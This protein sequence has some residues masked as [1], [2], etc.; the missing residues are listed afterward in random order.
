M[1][2]IAQRLLENNT[3]LFLGSGFSLEAKNATGTTVPSVSTL[4]VELLDA[5]GTPREEAES[6]REPLTDIA[7]Y[8]LATEAGAAAVASRLRQ[9]FNVVDLAPWQRELVTAFPWKRI[10]TTNYDNAVEVACAAKRKTV[11]VLSALAPFER[12]QGAGRTV[13]HINGCAASVTPKSIDTEV[14]LSGKSYAG[15]SSFRVERNIT[16]SWS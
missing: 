1:D 11:T 10:Y 16:I 9:L 6:A 14:R 5:I 13:I 15:P 4:G 3:I 2:A 7:D 12:P 8:C